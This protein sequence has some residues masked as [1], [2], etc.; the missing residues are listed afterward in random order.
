M[1]DNFKAGASM[2][3]EENFFEKDAIQDEQIF[4]QQFEY[5]Q[6]QGT[7]AGAD[8]GDFKPVGP[9]GFK[10]EGGQQPQVGEGDQGG[11]GGEALDFKFD[12][13]LAAEEQKELDELNARLNTNYKSRAELDA[14]LKGAEQQEQTS[15]IDK[16]RKYV[17]Y[18]TDLLNKEKFPD[19][20]LVKE[21]KI[22]EAIERGQNPKDPEVMAL[23][24]EQVEQLEQSGALEYAAKSIRQTLQGSLKDKQKKIA[25]FETSQ[26]EAQKQTA[27][28][29]KADLQ[30]SIGEIYKAGKFMGVQPTKE[31][32]IDI[33]KDV[34]KNRHIEHLKVNPRDA[35]EFALFKKYR[36]VISKN[37]GKPNYEAGVQA[38][39][40]ELG[41]SSDGQGTEAKDISRG[42]D[43]EDL[44]LLKRFAK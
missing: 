10:Q 42:S 28:K 34:S 31:D 21:D 4:K 20:A 36:E 22:A 29:F 12:D 39:L 1:E 15:E 40:K 41:M 2:E 30:E 18:F 25:D 7:P 35:V 11:Q 5:E 19:A 33:Y 9:E 43:Q 6:P 32:M 38:T 16:D 27:E 24:D 44:S 8:D 23:I 26:Q 37:L 14:A 13:A 17:N 3:L